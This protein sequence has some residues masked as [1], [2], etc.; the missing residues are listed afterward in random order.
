[1][2]GMV[3]LMRLGLEILLGVVSVCVLIVMLVILLCV[4]S[5]GVDVDVGCFWE[6]GEVWFWW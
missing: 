4:N 3:Y 1:M 2:G 6:L 5:G